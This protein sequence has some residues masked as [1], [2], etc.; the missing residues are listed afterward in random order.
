MAL[1]SLMGTR[2]GIPA[3]R[4]AAVAAIAF[5]AAAC[6]GGPASNT[7]SHSPAVTNQSPSSRPAGSPSAS[8]SQA[9]PSVSPTASPQ[10]VIGAYGVLVGSPAAS[11]YTVTI[12]GVGGKVAASAQASTPVAVTC[13]GAAAAVVPV[14]PVSTSNTRVYFMDA[15]GVVRFLSPDGSTG[16][17]TTVPVGTASRRSMFAVSPDDQRIA[18]IVDDFNSSGATTRLYVENLNGG[19]NHLD[20]FSQSV[21]FTLWPIGWHGTNNLV[22]A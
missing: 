14:S 7:A 18:V 10:P 22:L 16:Q 3:P 2:P 6:G 4:W 1:L 8:A 21:G 9:S 17:A 11:T 15:Q 13:A 19:G 20:L 5:L 12:V